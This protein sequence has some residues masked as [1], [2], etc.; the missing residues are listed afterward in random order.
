[1]PAPD[2]AR[3]NSEEAAIKRSRQI[4]NDKD[5]SMSSPTPPL[6]VG[7]GALWVEVLQECLSSIIPIRISRPTVRE[8]YLTMCP[9]CDLWFGLGWSTHMYLI[10]STMNNAP[11]VPSPLLSSIRQIRPV[12][13]DDGQGTP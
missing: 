9:S 2:P 6:D 10:D 7:A 11:P 4:D 12:P 5:E 8:C 13:P 1:M 3:P